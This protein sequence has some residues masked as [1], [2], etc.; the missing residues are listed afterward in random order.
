MKTFVAIR[1]EKHN[2]N[3]GKKRSEGYPLQNTIYGR[4]IKGNTHHKRNSQSF[5]SRPAD[6]HMETCQVKIV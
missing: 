6:S 5:S 1:L 4:T 3:K 2:R